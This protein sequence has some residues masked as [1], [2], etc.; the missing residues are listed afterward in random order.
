MD[1]EEEVSKKRTIRKSNCNFALLQAWYEEMYLTE[2]DLESPKKR[3]KT[4]NARKVL[5][6]IVSDFESFNDKV[7]QDFILIVR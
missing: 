4:K 3:S 6:V 7:L 2:R 5:V 1:T